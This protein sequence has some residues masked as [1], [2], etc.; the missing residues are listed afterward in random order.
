MRTLLLALSL[1][2][3]TVVQ[4]QTYRPLKE[5]LPS[6]TLY[7]QGYTGKSF[8]LDTSRLSIRYLQF[9]D[10]SASYIRMSPPD[11]AI[12]YY[13]NIDKVI[14]YMF[15]YQAGQARRYDSLQAENMALKAILQHITISGQISN[16]KGFDAAVKT[17][18]RLNTPKKKP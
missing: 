4:G 16:R 15:T 6:D 8:C 11:S 9:Q 12:T 7:L 13:G 1:I 2:A 3:C 18:M 14:R 17:Y 5:V 10:T